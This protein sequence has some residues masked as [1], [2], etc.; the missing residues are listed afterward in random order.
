MKILLDRSKPSS[1][2]VPL[3]VYDREGKRSWKLVGAV[4]TGASTVMIPRDAARL[5]G[6][7]LDGVGSKRVVCGDGVVYAPAITLGRVDVEGASA[8]GVEA[9]C[10]D[11]P[12]ECPVDALIGLSFLT[13]FRVAFDFDAWEM[14]LAPRA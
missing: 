6:Y 12:Q 10:H 4:D 11:L 7:Q 13:R 9:I 3:R 14:D 1:L 5:L 2:V 8:T